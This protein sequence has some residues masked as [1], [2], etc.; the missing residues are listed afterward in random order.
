MI[1]KITQEQFIADPVGYFRRAKDGDIF[2][3]GDKMFGLTFGNIGCSTMEDLEKIQNFWCGF[4]EG[5]RDVVRRSPLSQKELDH[6]NSPKDA[7]N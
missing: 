2:L 5:K 1:E 3:I 4:E 7:P 6:Y